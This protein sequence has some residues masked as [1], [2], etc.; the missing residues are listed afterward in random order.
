MN[1][2]LRRELGLGAAVMLGL[3]AM[4]GT[5][6]YAGLGYQVMG[7]PSGFPILLVW[8]LGGVDFVP[9]RRRISTAIS[10]R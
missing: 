1:E 9:R 5:G 7:L 6:V 4:V 10:K 2:Q 3:G 8:F